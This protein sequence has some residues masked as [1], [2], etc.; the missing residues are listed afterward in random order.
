MA[1]LL[2]REVAA[3]LLTID[4]LSRRRQRWPLVGAAEL[5][6]LLAAGLFRDTTMVRSQRHYYKFGAI[7]ISVDT[8]AGERLLARFPGLECV[9]A[10]GGDHVMVAG[11]AV[12]GALLGRPSGDVDIFVFGLGEDD[13][14]QLLHKMVRALVDYAQDIGES[15]EVLHSGHCISVLLLDADYRGDSRKFDFVLRLY[16]RPDQVLGCF[17]IPVCSI[18]YSPHLGI[19][20]TQLAAYR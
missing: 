13:A 8:E 16:E 17:D 4:W 9:F 7:S 19:V 10:A 12:V 15:V 5:H 14:T 18:G 1:T 2:T 6:R 20:A 3:A 11:G